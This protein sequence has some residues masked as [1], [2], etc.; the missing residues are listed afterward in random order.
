MKQVDVLHLPEE[1]LCQ[2]VDLLS[3]RIRDYVK[4]C[5]Q[6]HHQLTQRLYQAPEIENT[7][8]YLLFVETLLVSRPEYAAYV[9]VLD[10]TRVIGTLQT[11]RLPD[12]M[13]SCTQLREFYAPQAAFTPYM[14]QVLPGL[15]RLAVL[16][17]ASCI[18]R[19]E[20]SRVINY[21]SNLQFLHTFRY[22]RC[23]VSTTYPIKQYPPALKHLA[24]RGG[25]KDEFLLRMAH[26]NHPHLTI[27]SLLVAYA[28]SITAPPMLTLIS[29][30]STLLEL[31]ISWPIMRFN[32]NC[33]DSVL[34]AAPNLRFLSISIDYI[35]PRFFE[36]RHENLET[37]ELKFSGVGKNR[38]LNADDLMEAVDEEDQYP[39]LKHLGISP[40]LNDLLFKDAE[41]IE[42]LRGTIQSRGIRMYEAQDVQDVEVV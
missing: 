24:L 40:K 9:R 41:A 10:L 4:V 27:E 1:I 25:L 28:P 29:T 20:I 2:I 36:N 37:L 34:V 13:R 16:D 39:L 6:W 15:E 23:A 7:K 22:P 31:T 19:F 3:P 32:H 14:M 33:F 21:C 26:A 8:S 12:L 42:L 11:I 35:S 38:I 5:R 30:L 17:L 18:E